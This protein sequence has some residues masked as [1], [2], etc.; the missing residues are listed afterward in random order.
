MAAPTIPARSP[1]VVPIIPITLAA[2]LRWR[3]GAKHNCRSCQMAPEWVADS[4][5]QRWL[6]D[7]QRIGVVAIRK[8]SRDRHLPVLMLSFLQ[9]SSMLGI[10]PAGSTLFLCFML[11]ST[12]KTFSYFAYAK[13][14]LAAILSSQFS[15]RI[16]I[17]TYTLPLLVCLLGIITSYT[18]SRP[19]Y[20]AQIIVK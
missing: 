16:N 10:L 7:N 4:I 19:K 3:Q 1:V 13:P 20:L 15:F 5:R 12:V 14:F 8:E 11:G 2:L 18:R 6:M 17:E 9:K